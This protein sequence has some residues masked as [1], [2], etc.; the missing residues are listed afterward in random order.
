M[1]IKIS[2]CSHQG[3]L[4]DWCLYHWE[5]FIA[6]NGFKN[7]SQYLGSHPSLFCPMN[8]SWYLFTFVL[9]CWTSRENSSSTYIFLK[10]PPSPMLKFLSA[11]TSITVSKLVLGSTPVRIKI[12]V[13]GISPNSVTTHSVKCLYFIDT[14]FCVIV[15]CFQRRNSPPTCTS[16]FW[17]YVYSFI[18]KNYAHIQLCYIMSAIKSKIILL[19]NNIFILIH[20][21]PSSI[22]SAIS[23]SS[24][25]SLIWQ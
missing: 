18:I 8:Y 6:I 22:F 9:A 20:P 21:K 5:K 11:N 15:A 24:I 10:Q 1:L 16:P 7:M 2:S 13:K 12:H 14:F 17:F 25:Y 23:E 4:R 3:W 19:F